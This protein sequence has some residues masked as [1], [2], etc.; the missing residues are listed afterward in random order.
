MRPMIY[1]FEVWE[2]DINAAGIAQ[3]LRLSGTL[4]SYTT[5]S[6]L[7]IISSK[8]PIAYE[9]LL[10]LS[11]GRYLLFIFHEAHLWHSVVDTEDNFE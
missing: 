1:I 7:T 11:K 5:I 3:P 10:D 6:F 9:K 8:G 4:H 2:K